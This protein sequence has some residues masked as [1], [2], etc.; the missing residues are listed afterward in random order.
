MIQQAT[1]KI[2]ENMRGGKG[3]VKAENL[4]NEEQ[5]NG[6][7]RL[8]AKMTLEPGTSIGYHEHHNESETYYILS[9]EADYN[10]N[11]KIEKVKAGD[12]TFTPSGEGHGIENT[13]KEKLVFMALILLY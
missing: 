6:K 4:L 10:N 12:V 8:F 2:T 1:I 5:F 7:A 13:G 3:S 11:G 9:G